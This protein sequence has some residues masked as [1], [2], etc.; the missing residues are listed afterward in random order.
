MLLKKKLMGS[1][2]ALLEGFFGCFIADLH[3]DS[4]EHIKKLSS[5]TL[6][7]FGCRNGYGCTACGYGENSCRKQSNCFSEIVVK[8][9]FFQ[10]LPL[11]FW[12]IS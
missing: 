1:I 10:I 11:Y 12:M 3:G 8:F 7:L 2:I 5:E 6:L 9:C 4:I